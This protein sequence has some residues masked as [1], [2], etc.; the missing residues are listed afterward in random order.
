M[1]TTW[2]CDVKVARSVGRHSLHALYLVVEWA[3]WHSVSFVLHIEELNWQISVKA[4]DGAVIHEV[5][6]VLLL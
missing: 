5:V 4:D 2:L 1:D 3:R 6:K